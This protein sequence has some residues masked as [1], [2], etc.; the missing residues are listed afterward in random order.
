MTSG[1]GRRRAARRWGLAALFAGFL[2]GGCRRGGPG[3]GAGLRG[4]DGVAEA[5]VRLAL[6]LGERDADSLDFA[7]VPDTLKA[8]MH[9][10][11]LTL[12]AIGNQ[13]NALR[14]ELARM[15]LKSTAERERAEFLE[16]QLAAMAAR[17]AMLRGRKFAFDDEAQ[18]LFATGRLEDRWAGRRLAVRAQVARLLALGGGGRGAPASGSAGVSAAGSAAVRYAAYDGRFVVPPEK[19]EAVMQAAL[20]ACRAQTLKYMELP[21]GESITLRFVRNEPWSAFSRYGGAGQSTVSLNLDFPVTVDEVLELACHEGYPGHHVFN[22][23]REKALVKAGGRAEAEVQTTFSPQSY[24]SEAAAA[25]APRLAFTL[26]ERIAVE[27]TVLFPLAGLP[28]AEAERYVTI[29][30]LV[31]ELGSAEPAV[32]RAYLDDRLEFARAGQALAQEALMEHAESL[33]LYVNEYRSY[34][35]AYTDGPERVAVLLGAPGGVEAY[36][37]ANEASAEQRREEW[38]RFQALAGRMVW[39]LP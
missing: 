39:R 7:V 34:M 17:T 4:L 18:A 10:R 30:S 35:L 12:D 8:E 31:R 28:A 37:E 25:Y 3:A 15:P 6:A 26:A 27:R 14:G 32:A 33:L 5:Y 22:T 29:S 24:V 9:A 2:L 11:Y 38:R 36:G 1:G 19:L 21:A 20:G 16:L 13:A 23:L